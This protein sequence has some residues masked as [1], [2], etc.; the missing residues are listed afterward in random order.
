[1]HQ[2]PV[3]VPRRRYEMVLAGCLFLLAALFFGWRSL[4]SALRQWQAHYEF[5]PVLATVLKSEINSSAAGANSEGS[6]WHP[7]VA[8]R[9]AFGPASHEQNRIFYMGSGWSDRAAAQDWLA[10]Y[11]E[12]ATVTAY[13]NPSDPREAVLDNSA[14]DSHFLLYLLPFVLLGVLAV[15]AGL[16]RRP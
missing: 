15:I 5:V 4:Q 1:M 2:S 11:D 6:S 7:A 16:K 3:S 8:Y 14:P 10:R 9:Y 12:G 13:V